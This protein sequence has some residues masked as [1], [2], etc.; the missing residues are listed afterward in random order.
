MK[1]SRIFQTLFMA[2]AFL[3]APSVNAAMSYS[4]QVLVTGT[5][6][7]PLIMA[8]G[9]LAEEVTPVHVSR[10]L[11]GLWLGDNDVNQT[12]AGL[13]MKEIRQA[14][15]REARLAAVLKFNI[16]GWPGVNKTLYRHLR[17]A[18]AV[19][20]KGAGYHAFKAQK[21]AAAARARE[22]RVPPPIAQ[23]PETD[24]GFLDKLF[25]GR[26]KRM[27]R[28]AT[29]IQRNYRRYAA[30]R[31][32]ENRIVNDPPVA[33]D[34]LT[35]ERRL[36]QLKIERRDQALAQELADQA[37]R[38]LRAARE[39]AQR[40]LAQFDAMGPT[41]FEQAISDWKMTNRKRGQG[42]YKKMLEDLRSKFPQE[43]KEEL[44]NL[45]KKKPGKYE[46]KYVH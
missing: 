13:V 16:D 34:I 9:S 22:R 5:D 30:R 27:D 20:H 7:A 33:T 2:C 12:T 37:Y 40:T 43:V 31:D 41:R 19:P 18:P 32:M 45:K 14:R 3:A 10:R 46:G 29:T 42:W 38:D 28:A 21:A 26:A 1:L 6:G 8:D 25:G 4:A 39:R 44:R 36:K 35:L 11:N 15:T 24:R 17:G 23:K